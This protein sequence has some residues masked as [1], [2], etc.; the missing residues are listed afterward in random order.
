M[1]LLPS[2]TVCQP[3]SQQPG[4][5]ALH[6]QCFWVRWKP[7]PVL[8]Q[9]V[10]RAVVIPGMKNLIPPLMIAAILALLLLKARCCS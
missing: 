3:F 5:L 8:L 6:L 7:V 1:N 2:N 9:S 4:T 10:P